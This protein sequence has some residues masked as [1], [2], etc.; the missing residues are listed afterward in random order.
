MP[1][2]EVIVG[3][4]VDH[5]E[6]RGQVKA[7]KSVTVTGPFSAGDLQIVQI[8]RNGRL[9]QKGDVI[10]Q[11]DVSAIA[12]T[13]Q[14]K[15][16]DLEEADAN[17][18]R[19]RAQARIQEEKTLTELMQARYDVERARLDA[20]TEEII[21]SI[22]VEQNRLALDSAQRRL[23]AVEVKLESDRLIAAADTESKRQKREKI[24]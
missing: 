6:L 19:T 3:E 10:V 24:Q 4:F 16:S 20:A 5:L 14:Q 8:S 11:F 22:E 7:L 15:R 12:R 9:V 21:S 17:I 18:D 2:A 23:R 1:T 13:L